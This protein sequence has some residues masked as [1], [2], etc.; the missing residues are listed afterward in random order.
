[1]TA[2]EIT[3]FVCFVTTNAVWVYVVKVIHRDQIRLNWLGRTLRAFVSRNAD[4]I[5]WTDVDENKKETNR[6]ESII[7]GDWKSAIDRAMDGG[8]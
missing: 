1:M 5:I 2:L 8:E 3:L 6:F 7:D 4:V